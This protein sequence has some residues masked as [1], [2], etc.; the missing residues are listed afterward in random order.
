MIQAAAG[1][2]SFPILMNG[3]SSVVADAFGPVTG[4]HARTAIGVAALPFSV[5]IEIEAEV[6]LA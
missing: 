5:P 1:F 3:A 2:T 4:D 6:E